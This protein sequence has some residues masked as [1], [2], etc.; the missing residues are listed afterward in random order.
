[1]YSG[2]LKKLLVLGYSDGD[3]GSSGENGPTLGGQCEDGLKMIIMIGEAPTSGPDDNG[4]GNPQ[5]PRP[6]E[7]GLLPENNQRC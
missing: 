2:K 1:M 6:S 7:Q 3:L 4:G 5:D